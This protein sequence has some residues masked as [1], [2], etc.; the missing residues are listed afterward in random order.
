MYM[1]A[2]RASTTGLSFVWILY[3][4]ASHDL[5]RFELWRVKGRV[6][7]RYTRTLQKRIPQGLR[8][9]ISPRPLST[10]RRTSQERMSQDF[11]T[12]L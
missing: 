7:E 9:Q 10:G 11:A 6:V 2:G 3:D 5:R 1:K 8:V 4:N 12:S